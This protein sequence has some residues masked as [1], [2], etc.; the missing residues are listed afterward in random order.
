M[1]LKGGNIL[2]KEEEEKNHLMGLERSAPKTDPWVSSI[3]SRAGAHSPW[4]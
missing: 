4:C 2:Q 3:T 1:H